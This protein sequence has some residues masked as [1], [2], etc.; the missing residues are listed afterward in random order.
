M[1]QPDMVDL[2]SFRSLAAR[3]RLYP[4]LGML[5]ALAILYAAPSG[6]FA[7]GNGPD[8]PAPAARETTLLE[9]F[10]AGGVIGYT[11]VGISCV[12]F[13][14]ALELFFSLRRGAFTPRGLAEQLY[15]KISNGQFAEA[16]QLALQHRSLLSAIIR[17]GLQEVTIGYAAVEKAMEEAAQYHGARLYR[18]IELLS[19]VASLATMLGLL[20]TVVGLIRAFKQVAEAGGMV[21]ASDLATG[22]YQA[23]VT[24][25][26]GLLVAIPCL[27]L[28]ALL[29]NRL[30]QLVAETLLAAEYAFSGYKRGRARKKIESTKP[31]SA[32]Q[33]S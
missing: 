20:G 28:F 14:I 27:A 32:A 30:D 24:T 18:R 1:M 25:V 21:Q 17:T 31:R 3:S 26:E 12:A 9:L 4:V 19:V 29:R 2:A 15:E 23:L 5:V 22:I 7:Q 8:A 33:S 10:K 11:I 13:A 16:A 6:A